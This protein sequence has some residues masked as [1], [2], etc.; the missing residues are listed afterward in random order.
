MKREKRWQ[1]KALLA[2]C[3]LGIALLAA[4]CNRGGERGPAHVPVGGSGQTNSA[5]A[6]DAMPT[7][8]RAIEYARNYRL[9]YLYIISRRDG[10]PLTPDDVN[11]IRQNRPV[12]VAVSVITDDRRYVVLSS[13]VDLTPEHKTALSG[14]FN[15]ED[16]SGS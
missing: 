2:A 9:A 3:A 5:G 6:I 7:L 1:M 14:R 8:E 11:F 10:A 13:N 4:A 16:R 15:F 12:Q